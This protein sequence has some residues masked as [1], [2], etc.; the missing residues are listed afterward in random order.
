VNALAHNGGEFFDDEWYK[1]KNLFDLF[2]T[3]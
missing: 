1:K 2:K 3:L